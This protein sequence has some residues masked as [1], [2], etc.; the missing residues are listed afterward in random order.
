MGFPN[1]YLPTNILTSLL[2]LIE[3]LA[4]T[5]SK[6]VTVDWKWNR[7]TPGCRLRQ[8]IN[9]AGDVM[10]IGSTPGSGQTDISIN[11]S[12][13]NKLA[14][15]VVENGV[16]HF[17]PDGSVDAEVSV[18][19][20]AYGFKTIDANSSDHL[21]MDGFARSTGV[22]ILAA[23]FASAK[24]AV[25]SAAAASQALIKCEDDK[26]REWGIDAV[27]WRALRAPPTAIEPIQSLFHDY[28]YPAAALVY[29]ID[30]TVIARLS[31][32]ASGAI[33]SCTAVN[34]VRYRMFTNSVCDVLK[35]RATF[36]PALGHDGV[37]SP[38]P[39]MIV[40]RFRT[41]VPS[42]KSKH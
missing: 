41:K 20:D 7:D 13:L 35:K 9:S 32:D 40:V 38:A 22:Q 5:P 11:D 15:D 29:Q 28:D 37:P 2:A 23:K 6:A 14:E 19:R 34:D 42:H 31:V 36:K 24:V 27:S 17:V 18:S 3:A 21:L 30:P 10:E 4:A 12:R 8:E 33:S 16:I 39:Y 25:R 26:M 1:M